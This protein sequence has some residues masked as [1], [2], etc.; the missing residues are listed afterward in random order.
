MQKVYKNFPKL[1]EVQDVATDCLHKQYKNGQKNPDFFYE[2]IGD[3]DDDIDEVYQDM[4]SLDQ[5]HFV[6]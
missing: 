6:I 5:R 4:N 2:Q 3:E 1:K